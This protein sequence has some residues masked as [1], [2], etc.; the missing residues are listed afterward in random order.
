VP[1]EVTRE[2]FARLVALQDAQVRAYHDRFVG[3]TVRALIH[4]ISKKDAAR[5]T[6]KTLENVTVHFPLT[7]TTPD[8]AHPWVD[9]RIERA[10]VWGLA[11]TALG[12]VTRFD[13]L[14]I[15]VPSPTI[16]LT[17]FVT[18]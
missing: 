1:P 8:L 12:R 3:T 14:A 6:A 4:G 13:G 15:P 2:R 16:D 11:G 10:A 7:E 9:V 5:M 18:G 17:G